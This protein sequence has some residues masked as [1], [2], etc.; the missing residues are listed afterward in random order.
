VLPAGITYEFGSQM[1][2]DPFAARLQ[3]V[4]DW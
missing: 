3:K 1:E 4:R 2:Y